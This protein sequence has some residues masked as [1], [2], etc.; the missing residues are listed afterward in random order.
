MDLLDQQVISLLGAP[1][2]SKDIDPAIFN[3]DHRFDIQD[4]PG[5]GCCGGNSS[6]LFEVFQG[7]QHGDHTH[8]FFLSFDFLCDFFGRHSL[9]NTFQGV[10]CEDTGAD[11]YGAAV[12]NENLFKFSGSNDSALVGAGKL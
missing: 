8:I 7:V 3:V 10:F 2:F 12:H 5:E 1:G 6:S 9:F 11:G 4:A